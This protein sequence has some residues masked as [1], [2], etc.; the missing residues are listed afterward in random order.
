MK[1]NNALLTFC[2]AAGLV[3]P[4]GSSAQISVESSDSSVKIGPGGIEVKGADGSHVTIKSGA[5]GAV[6]VKSGNLSV[7][8]SQSAKSAGHALKAQSKTPL[9][10]VAA[11]AAAVP[12]D[13]CITN[14]GL[15]A[16]YNLQGQS[17]SILGTGCDITLKGKCKNL[18]VKGTGN[19][20]KA[21]AVASVNVSGT[22]NDVDWTASSTPSVQIEGVGNSAEPRN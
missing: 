6:S 22:G 11:P 21:D 1:I 9:L 3:F 10:K 20:V 12:K 7:K 16:T 17:V 2:L 15:T 5:A 13:L 4:A 14:T 18:T 19:T 8:G